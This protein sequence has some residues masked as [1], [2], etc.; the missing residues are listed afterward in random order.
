MYFQGHLNSTTYDAKNKIASI[1]P[2]AT[3]Q[4]VYEVITPQGVTVTGGRA[5]G[6]GAAGF[7][8]GGGNSF[9]STSHGWAC[10]NVQNFEV[11]LANGSIV[12]ANIDQ[13]NDLWQA[14]KG[15]SGNLGLVTR[16][17]MYIIDFPDPDV[18]DIWG[19]L[20]YFNLSS[21]DEVI[22]AYVDFVEHNHEDKNSS[23]MLYWV[24]NYAGKIHTE[25]IITCF[26]PR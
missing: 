24:Y 7:I 26:I 1:E 6:I 12:N 5:G 22:A 3:W 20:A 19:G 16:F 11:V 23:T 13:N 8:T 2:G 25:S 4:S 17:D 21:A 10:D 15:G 9:F 18:T 14:L